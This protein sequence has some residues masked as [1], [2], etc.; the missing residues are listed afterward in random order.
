LLQFNPVKAL[1]HFAGCF[2][3]NPHPAGGPFGL[4]Y[5]HLNVLPHWDM[6]CCCEDGEDEEKRLRKHQ[7]K[8]LEQQCL[9]I[10]FSLQ[11]R[12]VYGNANGWAY[13]CGRGHV[14]RRSGDPFVAGPPRS[15][16]ICHLNSAERGYF[17]PCE[18]DVCMACYHKENYQQQLT[19]QQ[20]L[21]A[22][23]SA[24]AAK[25]VDGPVAPLV[26]PSLLFPERSCGWELGC[27]HCGRVMMPFGPAPAL[28]SRGIEPILVRC[29]CCGA[30]Q[31]PE[32]ERCSQCD[33]DVCVDCYRRAVL[34]VRATPQLPLQYLPPGEQQT[35]VSMRPRGT[36]APTT[37]QTTVVTCVR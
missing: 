7:A 18:T 35:L 34:E 30:T 17:C 5:V 3:L 31:R 22:Q 23:G 2:Q 32:G 11:P 16:D 12:A 20:R 25:T 33:Y 9:G 6:P 21:Q 14:L 15:C 28:V 8:V 4:L 24:P 13:V 26:V 36:P 19:R 1:S 29:N 37:A 10:N 27:P